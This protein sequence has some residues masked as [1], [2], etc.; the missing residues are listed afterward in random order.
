MNFSV[1][2]INDEG[3]KH[4]LNNI[5]IL[6]KDINYLQEW[7][8]T[9]I[10]HE[11]SEPRCISATIDG[12]SFVY[13]FFIKRIEGYDLPGEYF[14]IQSAYGYGG[15]I[16]SDRK[17]SHKADVKFNRLVD[18]WLHDNH[19]IAEFIRDNPLFSFYRRNAL[20]SIVRTNVYVETNPG[21]TI[22]D[23]NTRKNVAKAVESG[24]QVMFDDSC[25]HLDQL[26]RLYKL[27]ANRI[28][29]HSY[30]HFDESYFVNVKNTLSEFV[31][32]IHIVFN[33][34]FVGSALYLKYS[35]KGTLHLTGS[36][37]TYQGLRINDLL[38]KAAIDLSIDQKVT[39]LNLG[40]GTTANIDDSLFRFK[41][42]YS[43]HHKNVMVGKNIIDAKQYQEVVRQ[44]S[45]R[46][47]GLSKKYENYFLKYRLES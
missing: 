4:A 8:Q 24:A 21:Y 17:V 43:R 16:T 9:W 18:E 29:M 20:Y 13:P 34:K 36:D 28:N 41:S 46:N 19:I 33:D 26:I 15:V 31:T 42:K 2:S 7:Y 5:P 39:I 37:M 14:D 45:I 22:P 10:D 30:Y 32:L 12:F 6:N 23:K 40:G 35:D 38:F 25:E 27:N 1:F 3:W 44:W 47:P 11:K